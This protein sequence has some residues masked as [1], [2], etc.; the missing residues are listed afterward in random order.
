MRRVGEG[1]GRGSFCEG[2]REGGGV[3]VFS[4]RRV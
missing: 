2:G 4:F 3:C 1:R